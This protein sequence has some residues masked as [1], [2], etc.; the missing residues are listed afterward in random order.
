MFG[1]IAMGSSRNAA[2]PAITMNAETTVA[3]SGRSMKKFEITARSRP[4]AGLRS[5]PAAAAARRRPDRGATR[6]K[7]T[8]SDRAGVGGVR[9][10][11][12]L[13]AALGQRDVDLEPIGL[14]EAGEQ[15]RVVAGRHEAAFGAHL[16][17]REAGDRRA[18]V[19]VR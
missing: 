14:D 13:R 11:H 1:Y 10:A 3:N 4:E 6:V 15:A 12:E 8:D 19:G 9:G 17:T 7:H 2:S 18:H 5:R 16:A